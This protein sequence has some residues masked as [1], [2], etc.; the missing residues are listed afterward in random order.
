MPCR[1]QAFEFS[2]SPVRPR[3]V[4]PVRRQLPQRS[5]PSAAADAGARLEDRKAPTC[6]ASHTT[7]RPRRSRCRRRD[8][9]VP[10]CG[11]AIRLVREH[12]GRELALAARAAARPARSPISARYPFVELAHGGC[13][14]A[15]VGW[16]FGAQP[17]VAIVWCAFLRRCWS[18]SRA[19]TGT[20]RC[21]LTTSRCRCS[22]PASWSAALGLDD[23]ARPMPI[24]GAVAGYLSLWSVYWALQAHDRQGRHGLRRLQAASPRSAPGSAGR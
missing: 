1:C 15:L 23:P 8:R 18:R 24:W 5:D 20:P 12:S 4:R 22:G 16:H 13:F 3:A 2:F 19:S 6:S 7:R 9:A 11:H 17:A 21:C 14:S 10:S